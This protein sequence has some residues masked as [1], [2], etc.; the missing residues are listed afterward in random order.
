M[1]VVTLRDIIGLSFFGLWV[2]FVIFLLVYKTILDYK[3]N[4]KYK[5]ERL[6]FLQK[7]PMFVTDDDL[8]IFNKKD[9]PR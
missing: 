8:K 5:K 4:K 2:L 6:E 3:S 1:I 9:L 7:H